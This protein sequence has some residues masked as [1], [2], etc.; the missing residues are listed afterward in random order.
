MSDDAEHE[1]LPWR[2]LWQRVL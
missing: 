1:W 2:L